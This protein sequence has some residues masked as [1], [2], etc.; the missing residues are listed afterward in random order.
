M[1]PAKYITYRELFDR[2]PTIDEI[3]TIVKSLNAFSTVL[4]CSRL[5]TMFRHAVMSEDENT[6]TQFQQWFAAAFFDAVT[7]Q[8]LN[9]RFGNQESQKR[10]V[11]H[12]QQL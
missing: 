8:R 4:L 10:P 2:V 9:S 11:C 6:L 1:P 12:P 7:F 3:Q 5:S